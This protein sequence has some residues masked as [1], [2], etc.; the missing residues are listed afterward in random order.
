MPGAKIFEVEKN[1]FTASLISVLLVNAILGGCG[2]A[3]Q[4]GGTPKMRL[5]LSIMTKT[6]SMDQVLGSE[7]HDALSLIIW[8]SGASTVKCR[9][10][11]A[12]TRFFRGPLLLRF[13]LLSCK[14]GLQEVVPILGLFLFT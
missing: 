12:P 8:F 7:L 4:G 10:A 11:I 13:L 1:S 14:S 9:S 6:K 2:P 3:P 5:P